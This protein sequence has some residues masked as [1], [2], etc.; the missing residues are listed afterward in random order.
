M[1]LVEAIFLAE[2]NLVRWQEPKRV[3]ASTSSWTVF[4]FS[5]NVVQMCEAFSSMAIVPLY[6]PHLFYP[7]QSLNS[8]NRR[9]RQYTSTMH[10]RES[11]GEY[12][13]ERL[14]PDFKNTKVVL[15]IPPVATMSVARK[16]LD[17]YSRFVISCLC[18]VFL[19]N[20]WLVGGDES[21]QGMKS[22]V[23]VLGRQDRQGPKRIVS[24]RPT[25][26]ATEVQAM[27]PWYGL[28]GDG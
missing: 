27:V 16:F 26:G 12:L 18:W 7:R 20:Q 10:Y 2:T 19:V 9:T 11:G 17:V 8:T 22:W 14:L 24:R 15:I 21:S 6:H 28:C 1:P 25:K 23:A 3:N 13:A 4:L 5:L